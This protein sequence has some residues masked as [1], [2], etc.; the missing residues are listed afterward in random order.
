MVVRRFDLAGR[1]RLPS[2]IRKVSPSTI[3]IHRNTVGARYK[4]ENPDFTGSDLEATAA[5]HA[6]KGPYHFRLFPY[7]Y[8]I[9]R[10]GVTYQVHEEMM[11]TPHA[12]GLNHKAVGICLN[13]DGRKEAPTE[14][15]YK[16]L[17]LLCKEIRQ[18]RPGTGIMGHSKHKRCPGPLVDIARVDRESLPKS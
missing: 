6:Q 8:Y 12:R 9:D 16:S 4:R 3:V 17:I 13:V 10:D 2:D 1:Y 11:I 7:H 5:F 14:E 15:M 18:K